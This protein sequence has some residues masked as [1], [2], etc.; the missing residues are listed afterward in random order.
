VIRFSLAICPRAY[1]LDHVTLSVQEYGRLPSGDR[2]TSLRGITVGRGREGLGKKN[3]SLNVSYATDSLYQRRCAHARQNRSWGRVP[4]IPPWYVWNPRMRASIVRHALP[5]RH[6]AASDEREQALASLIEP[7]N[8]PYCPG[9]VG[10]VLVAKLGAQQPL[11]RM[12]AR[13]NRR[14]HERCQQ[15]AHPRPKG[16]GPP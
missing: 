11:F 7:G 6:D 14:D 16:Q 15:H 8:Q 5:H 10:T 12:D 13:E 2:G 9:A 3:Q 4:C 1:F